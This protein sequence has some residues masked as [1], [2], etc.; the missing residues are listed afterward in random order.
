V[1]TNDSLRL[2]RKA[3]KVERRRVDAGERQANC[4]E[5]SQIAEI[6]VSKSRGTL[7]QGGAAHLSALPKAGHRC[8]LDVSRQ[9]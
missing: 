9:G 6:A 2:T 4:A 5:L 8:A 1:L 7:A 3:P